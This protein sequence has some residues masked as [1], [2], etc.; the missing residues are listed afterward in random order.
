M[1]WLVSSITNS[2]KAAADAAASADDADEDDHTTTTTTDMDPTSAANLDPNLDSP[3]RGVKDDLSELSKT[4]TRQFW[5]VASFLAP[6]PP[7]TVDRTKEDVEDDEIEAD[8]AGIGGIRSDLVEIGGRVRT[9]IAKLSSNRAVEELTKMASSLMRIGEGEEEDGEERGWVEGKGEDV[10]GVTDDVVAF[11]R[12]VALHPETWLDF[13]LPDDEDNEDDVEADFELSDAQ[14]AHALAVEHL[15]PRL[16]A[17][18]IELCP[19]YMSEGSFW[20]IYFVLV[21]PRLSKEDALLLSTPQIMEARAMLTQEYHNRAKSRPNNSTSGFASVAATDSRDEERLA[22]PPE[23][24]VET[25]PIELSADGSVTSAVPA[26]FDDYKHQVSSTEI[27]IIDKAVVEEGPINKSSNNFAVASSSKGANQMYEDEG[28]DW[29]KEDT[30]EIVG[31]SGTTIP[32]SNDEDVSF[33]DLEDDE[34]VPPGYKGV[35][36]ADPAKKESRDW[37]TLNN[38]QPANSGKDIEINRSGKDGDLVY[39]D[40][41]ISGWL[42]FDEI[43]ST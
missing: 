32:I 33:S 16:A 18:R 34:D 17:L 1:S 12:D 27:P 37:V 28:D 4:L 26:N 8:A 41:E 19:G 20:K 2:L 9:G 14:Q 24:E 15:A 13:P 36:N 31:A 22:A 39:E 6:P 21:H 5:G 11:A 30:A 3:R 29:L 35:A 40:K 43:D 10:V 7:V 23:D 38:K 42:D 25:L